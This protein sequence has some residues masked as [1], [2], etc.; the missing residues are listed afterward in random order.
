MRVVINREAQ[1]LVMTDESGAGSRTFNLPQDVHIQ[2][3]A[4]SGQ[5]ILEGPLEM[6]FLPNG[7]SSSAEI[8]LVSSK[9]AVLRIVSDPI[10]GAARLFADSREGRP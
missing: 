7:S 10:T 8:L 1:S 5:E 2:R 3:M 9:G 6:H 4:V